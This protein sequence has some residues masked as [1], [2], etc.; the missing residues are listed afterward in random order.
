LGIIRNE[1][2]ARAITPQVMAQEQ[3]DDSATDAYLFPEISEILNLKSSSPVKADARAWY[4]FRM[5]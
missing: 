2:T 5:T 1:H 4:Q 3:V